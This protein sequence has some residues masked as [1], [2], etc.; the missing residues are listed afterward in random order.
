ML[1]VSGKHSGHSDTELMERF[2][3]S[4]DLDLLGELYARY[5]HLVFGVALKYLENRE[6]ACDT[7][8]EIFEFLVT[9]LPSH[10]VRNFKSWL[11][12]LTKNHCL[13]R[14]RSDKSEQR[15]LE[16]VKSG[17][18]FMESEEE[19]HP[20]DREDNSMEKALQECME[21]LK[22]E[23][24]QCIELFYYQKM[25]YR[26]VADSLHLSEKQVKS[27]LQNG[28]RNLRICL[29]EKKIR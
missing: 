6:D 12:V 25:C 17:S 10:E 1:T 21:K 27:C 8:M 28:K 2:S 29:E 24:K 14:I 19:V 5:M 20:I 11:Y 9:G 26:E 13:M 22:S 15:R 23:Q 18:M 4:G 16:A 7:V 3:R